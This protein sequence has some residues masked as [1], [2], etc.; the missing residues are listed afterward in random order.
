MRRAQVV[1]VCFLGSLASGTL[2]AQSINGRASIRGTITAADGRPIPGAR[3]VRTGTADSVRSDSLGRYSLE[4]LALGRHIFQVR[5]PGFSSVEMEVTF[6][7]DTALTLDIPLERA[8]SVSAAK[9]DRVGFT[10]RRQQAASRGQA[11]ATF[12]GPEE[13][14]AKAAPRTSLLFD[15]VRDLTM[16]VVGSVPVAYGYD[17]R[18]VM[19]VWLEGRRMDGVFPTQELS[20]RNTA[21]RS[22]TPP[23][24]DQ[25][26]QI[27]DIAAIEIYPRPSKTPPQFQ[28]S[29]Q[30]QSGRNAYETRTADCGAIVIWTT[31]EQ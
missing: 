16:R 2:A 28:S 13:V 27:G 10:Q 7:N 5:A 25:L 19:S 15:G 21:Q 20:G 31:Q 12:L 6:T 23:G 17:G 14:I 9:L 30:V 11:D 4:R 22:T 18:C 8:N 1:F 29:A 24:L 3:V 26:V